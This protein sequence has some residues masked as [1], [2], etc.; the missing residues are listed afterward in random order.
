[1]EE[2]FQL[3]QISP[4][5]VVTPQLKR[6]IQIAAPP[7]VIYEILIDFKEYPYWDDTVTDIEQ[8]WDG[9]FLMRTYDLGTITASFSRIIPF[10]TVQM[11]LE[12]GLLGDIKFR[13]IPSRCNT[14][15][16]AE[17]RVSVPNMEDLVTRVVQE[18]LRA[19]KRLA[20]MMTSGKGLVQ[21]RRE[22]LPAYWKEC[23]TSKVQS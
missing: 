9:K 1:M 19:I 17:F 8:L 14:E 2:I 23:I 10:Q 16:T 15:V 3:M 13:I 6:K 11:K 7:A 12:G 18:K 20:E 22:L 4:L 21:A 5:K